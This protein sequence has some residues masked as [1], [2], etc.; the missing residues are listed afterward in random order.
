MK[1]A[2]PIRKR[3]LQGKTEEVARDRTYQTGSRIKGCDAE[4]RRDKGRKNME[5]ERGGAKVEPRRWRRTC[6][7]A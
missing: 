2:T 3:S 5:R 6:S 7:L 1:L 4:E